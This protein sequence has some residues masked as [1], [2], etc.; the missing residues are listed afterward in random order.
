VRLRTEALYAFLLLAFVW[1]SLF[2]DWLPI[3][4]KSVLFVSVL[5]LGLVMIVAGWWGWIK[6]RETEDVPDWQKGAGL[7]GA[8][9]NT[10]LAIPLG[11]LLYRMHYP[12]SR[13]A[14]RGVSIASA[15]R[16]LLTSFVLSLSAVI[17]G[18]FAPP[19]CRFVIILGGLIIGSIVLSI[20]VGFV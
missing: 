17:A 11:S 14:M 7:A 18:I 2:G 1:V 6:R 12:F 16:V 3:P 19:R 9:A 20:P 4:V 5:L 10:A 8:I 15:E 13:V